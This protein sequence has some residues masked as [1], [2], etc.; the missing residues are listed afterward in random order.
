MGAVALVVVV[1][2]V[3]A[4]DSVVLGGQHVAAEAPEARRQAQQEVSWVLVQVGLEVVAEAT[5]EGVGWEVVAWAEV[6]MAVEAEALG[7]RLESVETAAE[8]V[9]AAEQKQE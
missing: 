2:A 7:E 5:A 8:V 3:A 4:A 9:A 6:A 1:M